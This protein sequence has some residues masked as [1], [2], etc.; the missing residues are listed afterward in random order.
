MRLT[1]E[2]F[3]APERSNAIKIPPELSLNEF[4][5]YFVARNGLGEPTRFRQ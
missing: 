2:G 1:R 5:A 3:Y 4:L